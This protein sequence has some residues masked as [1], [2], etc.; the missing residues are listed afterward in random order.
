MRLHWIPIPPSW[1]I[2]T[3]CILLAALPHQI[4]RYIRV[5]LRNPI[6]A[7]LFAGAAIWTA[8]RIPH[9]G[10]AML[11][12]LAGLWLTTPAMTEGFQGTFMTKDTV[13]KP[14]RQRKWLNEEIMSE[15]P[16]SI[17]ELSG[18]PTA[19]Q[20]EITGPEHERWFSEEVLDEHPTMIQ[21]RPVWTRADSDD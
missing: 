13:T 10:V 20:D 21:D 5:A 1:L 16:H 7:L 4:P 3:A 18:H 17:Q 15:D 2:S 14:Q 19:T 8:M 12:L 11:L 6:G 9:L